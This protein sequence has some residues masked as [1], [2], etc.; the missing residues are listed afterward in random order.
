MPTSRLLSGSSMP[1]SKPIA[2]KVGYLATL[3]SRRS[4][5]VTTPTARIQTA[6]PRIRTQQTEVGKPMTTAVPPASNVVETRAQALWPSVAHA[7]VSPTQPVIREVREQV[8]AGKVPAVVPERAAPVTP[9]PHTVIEQP[10]RI[11]EVVS[12]PVVEVR[13]AAPIRETRTEVR[14]ITV[15]QPVVETIVQWPSQFSP[16]QRAAVRTEIERQTRH[17]V[18]EAKP[19]R[20]GV[21]QQRVEIRVDQLNVRV[22]APPQSA[23][24]AAPQSRRESAFSSF[25]MNRSLR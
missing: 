9:P 19:S 11:V 12:E 25:F 24:A 16:M 13:E 4:Q 6:A 1:T 15:A 7:P 22:D 23:P 18:E 20:P 21:V 3:M 17:R 2:P 14:T 8:V 10:P 5:P